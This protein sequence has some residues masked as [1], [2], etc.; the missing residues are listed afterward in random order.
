M[1]D[2]ILDLNFGADIERR[3]IGIGDKE[4]RFGGIDDR[5]SQFV[6]GVVWLKLTSVKKSAKQT[7][8]VVPVRI[9]KQAIYLVERPNKSGNVFKPENF[10]KKP[11]EIG[12]RR[13]VRLPDCVWS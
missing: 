4:M 10:Q 3:H 12:I 2:E 1:G 5:E 8:D 13:I 9:S 11:A 6:P 7:E